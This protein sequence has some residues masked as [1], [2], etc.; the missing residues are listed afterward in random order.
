[1]AKIMAQEDN[2]HTFSREHKFTVMHGIIS[3]EKSPKNE[4][5]NTSTAKYKKT[6]L[7]WAGEAETHSC[8]KPQPLGSSLRSGRI[9]KM[10][11]FSLRRERTMSHICHPN[12]QVCTELRLQN[13]KPMSIRFRR[14]KES[15]GTENMFLKGSHR[16][17]LS[18]DPLKK[19]HL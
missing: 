16:D 5:Y 19:Q 6:S 3:S 7:R 15:Q 1:M 2:E 17:S 18:Q 12:P 9:S 10:K 4:M 11:H 13:V 14:T 8:Q